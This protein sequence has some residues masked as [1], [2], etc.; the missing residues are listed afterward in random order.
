MKLT[1]EQINKMFETWNSKSSNL[2][3]S[4]VK[5]FRRMNEQERIGFVLENGFKA[6]INLLLPII[7]KQDEAIRFYS[8]DGANYWHSDADNS[9]D[10]YDCI[11]R[12]DLEEVNYFFGGKFKVAG[13]LARS[14]KKE[15]AEMIKRLGGEDE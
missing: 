6:A 11:D 4:E 12:I 7:Q 13:K 3:A 14:T 15:V 9:P 5:A 8:D 10:V 1:E 2:S